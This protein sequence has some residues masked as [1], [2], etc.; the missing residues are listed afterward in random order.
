MIKALTTKTDFLIW[1]IPLLIISTLVILAKSPVFFQYPDKLSIGITLDF[2]VTLPL[3]FYLLIRRKNLPWIVVIPVATLGIILAGLVLPKDHQQFLVQAKMIS[4][5]LMELMVI[6]FLLIKTRKAKKAYD[7]QKE[8]SFDFYTALKKAVSEVVPKGLSNLLSTEIAV[9]Y[10]GFI[11]W[12]ERKLKANEFTCHKE[13]GAIPI[14][15]VIILLIIVE[16]VVQHILVQLFSA[17][18]AWII[19][20]I[21]IYGVFV[22]FGIARSLSKRPVI[23]T[24]DSIYLRYGIISEAIIFRSNIAS[25]EISPRAV[26]FNKEVILLSPLHKLENKN[27]V[28]NLREEGILNGFYGKKK[29]FKSIV[30]YIDELARFRSVMGERINS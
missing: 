2:V 11:S 7:L 28:I 8:A 22:L 9:F 4:F 19:T 30:L 12:N 26:E 20:I 16:T 25:I 10:Y 24:N 17:T 23:V 18:I 1:L 15:F 13:N 21:S 29:K 3:V 5:S 14:F 27:V 6:A